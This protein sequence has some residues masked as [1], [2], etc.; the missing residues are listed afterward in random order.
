MLRPKPEPAPSMLTT[1]TRHAPKPPPDPAETSRPARQAMALLLP[2]GVALLASFL[3]HALWPVLLP[4]L[5]AGCTGLLLTRLLP[6]R[7][8]GLRLAWLPAALAGLLW[9]VYAMQVAYGWRL[10][11]GYWAGLALVFGWPFV[12]TLLWAV[13]IAWALPRGLSR[14]G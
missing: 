14:L 4:L 11:L 1:M 9:L 6:G 13:L 2:V 3:L 5:G 12:H 10:E 8:G 7:L